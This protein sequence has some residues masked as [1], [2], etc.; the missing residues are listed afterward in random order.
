MI[1]PRHAPTSPAPPRLRRP[2]GEGRGR[3]LGVANGTAHDQVVCAGRDGGGRGR[4]AL[5]VAE[6]GASRAHA[7]HHQQPARTGRAHVGHFLR[8]AHD[9]SGAGLSAS[10]A[11]RTTASRMVPP[12]PSARKSSSDRLV[13]TVTPS[14]LPFA[15]WPPGPPCASSR[16]RPR[17]A[18]SATRRPSS[19]RRT[20]AR[21]TVSGMSCSF[22]SRKTLPPALL[23][24]L[25]GARALG[26]EQFQAD[27]VETRLSFQA[28]QEIRQA[29]SYQARPA[30]RSRARRA[31]IAPALIASS[32]ARSATIFSLTTR[33]RLRS[34]P[35]PPRASAA[36]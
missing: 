30:R 33:R 14:G 15:P 32:P 21:A 23:Y 29:G 17:C 31:G 19:S 11:R 25:D 35:S 8:R 20:T 27:L 26:H 36:P 1:A 16:S 28:I 3:A 9:A 4:Y 13:N 2:G 18:R 12:M 24:R 34:S 6:R 22:R 7:G 5:L 10:F